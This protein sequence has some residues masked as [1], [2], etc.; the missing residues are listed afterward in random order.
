MGKRIWHW[1][2]AHLTLFKILFVSSVLVFVVIELGRIAKDLN[3]AAVQA[4]FAT[5]SPWSLVVLAVVGILAVTPMLNYDFTITAM[6]PGDYKPAYVVRSGWIVNTFTNIAGFGG[7]LGA[8]LRANFYHKGATQKQVLYAISKIA[9]FL[10]AGLS[11]WSLIA[12]IMIFGVGIG[13]MYSGYWIWL[14]GGAAYFPGLM[15]VTHLTNAAFFADLPLKR[16]LRLTLGS[17]LEWGAAA[18][19]FLLIGRLLGADAQLLHLLPL[20][21]IANVLGVISMVPG[22]LGSFD[23]FMILGL[24]AV[25]VNNNVAVVWLLFY[26]LFYYVIPFAIGALFFAQDLGVRINARLEGLPHQVLQKIAH[27]ALVGF[28]YF[29]AVMLLLR[30]VV[31]DVAMANRVYQHLYPFTFVFL[32]RV[33]NIIMAFVMLGFAR[34]VANR[35]KKAFWPTLI[36]LALA[37]VASIRR[38]Y[39][40]K[41]TILL[42]IVM[43]LALLARGELTRQRMDFPWGNR[44]ID[45]GIFMVTGLFYAVALFYNLP[46]IHHRHPIPDVFFFPSEHMW[47]ATFVSVVVAAV[48]LLIIYRYLASP[49][50]PLGEPVDAARVRALVDR[51]GGNAVSHL[52]LLPDREL[53]FYQ[54][55]GEDSVMFQFRKKADKL[56]I[57]GEPVGDAAALIPAIRDFIRA[58]DAQDLS[59]VFYEI[60]ETLTMQLHEYGFDFMKFGEEGYVNVQNFSLAGTKRKG[61]RALIHKFEREG[62]TYAWLKPPLTEQTLRELRMV[63]DDWLAGRQEDGFSL[64]YF[65]DHY[66]NQAPVA[67]IRNHNGTIVSFASAMP[68]ATAT[69]TSIDL[70]RSSTDAPSGIMDGMFVNLFQQAKADGFATFNMGMAPLANV[71]RSDYA[72]L[73]EKMAHLVYQY[74]YR[75]YGFQGLRSYKEKYVTRWLPKYVAYRKRSSLL[76]TLLQILLVVN[77]RQPSG[78]VAFLQ[79]RLVALSKLGYWLG[80]TDK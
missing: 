76:F 47:V 51:F 22:G 52:A 74:G 36:I 62:Y 68:T 18:F 12:L 33:T 71:G 13:A 40:L 23:V 28:M 61:E 46:N 78:P 56:I 31:P 14:I 42:V 5:Q 19:F 7:L 59:L 80:G 26:R 66:L 79:K 69:T 25:G 49:Y 60:S 20:F 73:E 1:F 44:L 2:N 48:T 65:D 55:D 63:S 15:L 34:G 72:F 64:G 30:G 45:A 38:E 39:S 58:A 37:T 9:L 27:V 21:F 17:F 4:A 50:V 53:R 67:V 35:V 77:Q 54:V 70:M 3:G 75:F 6:L 11:L 32:S 16:E 10:L 43:A 41:F 24:S 29:C 57:L 8:S